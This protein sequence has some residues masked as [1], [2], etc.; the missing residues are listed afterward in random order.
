MSQ[1]KNVR[2]SEFFKSKKELFYLEWLLIE[3]IF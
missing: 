3:I 2:V 1:A